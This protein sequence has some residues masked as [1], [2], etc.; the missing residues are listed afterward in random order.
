M[1]TTATTTAP[2]FW[3]GCLAC[4][5]AADLV[6]RWVDADELT[7]TITPADIHHGHHRTSDCEELWVFD[8]ENVPA[9][10]MSVAAAREWAEAYH[11]AGP[12]DWPAV[13]AWVSSGAAQGTSATSDAPDI[14]AFRD[15]YIGHW[16]TITDYAHDHIEDT[17]LLCQVPDAVARYFDVDSY[18]HD[19]MGDLVV[20]DA[21]DGG[22]HI[23]WY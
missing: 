16:A 2:A 3:I 23:F 10:E 11:R 18:A 1:T 15:A 13:S 8:H 21:D 4:H 6:G 7:D 5:N 19:L 20:V 22:V 14:A 12:A 9:G 17:G